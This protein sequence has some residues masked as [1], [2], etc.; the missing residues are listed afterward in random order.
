MMPLDPTPYD[1]ADEKANVAVYRGADNHLHA[2]VITPARPL[3]PHEQRAMPHF[4]TCL[5][6]LAQRDK[7]PGVRSLARARAKRGR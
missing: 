6:E 5:V 3:A 2:R 1:R 7:V 4:A